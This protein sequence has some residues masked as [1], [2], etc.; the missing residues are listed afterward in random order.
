M[1]KLAVFFQ[2]LFGLRRHD[3]RAARTWIRTMY[4]GHSLPMRVLHF[5]AWAL[6]PMWVRVYRARAWASFRKPVSRTPIWL[7]GGNPFEN[8]PLRDRPDAALPP[9]ALVVLIGAGL[10]GGAMAYHW[11]KLVRAT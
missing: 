4:A 9:E 8:Y 11:S 1:T 2:L 6:N 7:A 10:I 3:F 5:A